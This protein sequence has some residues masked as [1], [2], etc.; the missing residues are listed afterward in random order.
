MAP[1]SLKM[2]LSS[3]IRENQVSSNP[4]VILFRI[5][6]NRIAGL[7]KINLSLT[8]TL[9]IFAVIPETNILNA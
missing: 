8:F 7:Y 5:F 6:M 4:E 1:L 3:S 9:K 2:V